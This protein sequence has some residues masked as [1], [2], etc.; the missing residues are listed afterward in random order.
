MS[1]LP[2]LWLAAPLA[3]NSRG[4]STAASVVTPREQ[5]PR[6]AG[7]LSVQGCSA[8]VGRQLGPAIP[9]PC[10]SVAPK[11]LLMAD[12]ALSDPGSMEGRG[13]L[14]GDLAE[15]LMSSAGAVDSM[16]ALLWCPEAV[17]WAATQ[18]AASPASG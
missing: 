13:L 14:A 18:Q 12:W 8:A 5:E 9:G 6:G 2:R 16:L 10:M 3:G 17:G 1:W 11:E 4:G 15:E 7:G